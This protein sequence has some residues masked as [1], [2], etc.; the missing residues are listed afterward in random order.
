M[1]LS[2]RLA[3][4]FGPT[5]TARGH[6]HFL[7]G[8]VRISRASYNAIEADISAGRRVTVALE[9]SNG[10]LFADC[11]C[12]DSYS[13]IA[14]EHIWATI[15]VAEAR[16][17]FPNAAL[18]PNLE[19]DYGGENPYE[20]T[21]DILAGPSPAKQGVC[22][23]T[24]QARIK[25][26]KKRLEAFS[27]QQRLAAPQ[28]AKWPANRELLY[29]VDVQMSRNHGG[30]II[31]ILSHTLKSNGTWT[32][33]KSTVIKADEIGRLPLAEDRTVVTMLAGAVPSDEYGYNDYY[34][35]YY[36][37]LY[38]I[39]PTLAGPLLRQAASTGR[40][41]L[42]HDQASPSLLPLAW[43]DGEAWRFKLQVLPHAKRGWEITG[44][45]YRG[46][47]RME[48]SALRLAT[49]GGLIF[50][51]DRV[52]PLAEDVEVDW[53]MHMRKVGAVHVP[54]GD[55]DEMLSTLL[56][57]PHLP[58]V[59][60][61]GELGLEEISAPPSPG[62]KIV[63][64]D[65]WMADTKLRAEPEFDYGNW[66]V[67]AG[68]A[69]SGS[70]D[71]EKQRLLRRNA[72]AEQTALDLL[73]TLGV[74]RV[75][76]NYSTGHTQWEMAARKLP[77]VV[78]ALIKAGWRV[79]AHGKLFRHPSA[80]HLEVASGIDWFELR[81]KV[82]FDSTHVELPALL[83]AL[84]RGEKMVLL[85]D[86]SMGLLPE[87][88]LRRVL[89]LARFGS[90]Q[91]DHI[92]FRSSQAGL[93]DA[94][95]ATE[96]EFRCD[97]T[98]NRVRQEM[99]SFQ[100]VKAARQPVGFVGHLRDYQREGLGWML[101]LDRFSFGGCLADDMG[102]GKTAQVLALL[103]TRRELRSSG[104]KI[105][106]SLV[107]VPRSLVFN[108]KEEAA[109]FT[110][111][112]R[113][114][115]FTGHSRSVDHFD[116]HHLIITTYG[117]LRREILRLK[118][119]EFDYI[120]LDEAQTIKNAATESAKAARLLRGSRRLALSGTPVENHLGEL[121]SLFEFLNPGML[122]SASIFKM[123]GAA[124]RNPDEAT[125]RLLAHALRPFILRRTKGQ[126]A[127]ELPPKTELTVQCEMD[128]VQR[129]LYDELRQHYHDAL[130]KRVERE[131]IGKSA[132][133]VLEALL[134]LRQAACHP[135]LIDARRRGE[136]SAK[137]VTLL[138]QV[139][140]VMDEGHK[141][142]VFSQ[143]TSLLS[144]VRDRLKAKG[145][146]HEY[147][148]GATHNRQKRVERF[149]NDPDCRLFLISLKAGGLGL[150]LTAAE[151]VFLLDPWWNPAVEAQAMDRAHRIGQMR[152]VF[153][154]RLI[155]RDTVEE[156]ILD[157]QK[158]KL[159]MASA[160]ISADNSLI[161]NL[162]REDLELLLS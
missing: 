63:P 17:H 53:L 74:K 152:Q 130:L 145:I 54:E 23:P 108:W 83:E 58:P 138:E 110:P 72:A 140:E 126:V 18:D 120:V 76:P 65:R 66:V 134:R 151:Y 16:K 49:R 87:E 35:R 123:T 3:G 36:R 132:I 14:C 129:K 149:Q 155:A 162:Q 117:T 43:D 137:L 79:E 29:V 25:S 119:V 96:L 88:W 67:R 141:A 70:Y 121:W 144:I 82:D 26:W 84:R 68:D 56:R 158:R 85:G 32:A 27:E 28:P 118:Q 1:Y 102:V 12:P 40:C 156:K 52:A 98:F 31:E 9:Y 104:E 19:L 81:G 113:V 59:E 95:L 51:Q 50:T 6:E 160:I 21:D 91:K 55:K 78:R 24:P 103:E 48:A 116:S 114:L 107:V 146:D 100:G 153:A 142:L 122:G 143:F 46:E 5:A 135:G 99:K 139:A 42:R 154:Y 71:A 20:A 60:L 73:S 157:L 106:P 89:G 13:G 105:P 128:P 22:L 109:R 38:K 10:V 7:N 150:N 131:G 45:L 86:G 92:R 47:E 112:L 101:F 11:D 37:K 15:L 4:A 125:R 61:P 2:H 97:E 111:Q 57:L 161:H 39:A 34:N 8:S 136:T 41:Y 94:L 33:L 159:D 64:A 147:L 44:V 90:A 77:D 124:A 80:F 75:A 148:D 127:S 62:L 115:D 93:L 69:A 133:Q 30:L